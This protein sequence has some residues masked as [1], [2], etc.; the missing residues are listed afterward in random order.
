MKSLLVF[1]LFQ[2][3]NRNLVFISFFFSSLVSTFCQYV[4]L[5]LFPTESYDVSRGQPN[6][7][8]KGRKQRKREK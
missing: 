7:G 3:F 2:S 4:L 1:F 8:E 5:L 6:V